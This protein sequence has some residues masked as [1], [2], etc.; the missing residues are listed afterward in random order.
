MT[1]TLILLYICGVECGGD[2]K[3]PSGT[4]ERSSDVIQTGKEPTKWALIFRIKGPPSPLLHLW[5][6]GSVRFSAL[7]SNQMNDKASR[8][9]I[10]GTIIPYLISH[11]FPMPMLIYTPPKL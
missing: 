10:C 11:I 1:I 9:S 6:T 5:S 2:V 4:T 7:C 3:S 8:S